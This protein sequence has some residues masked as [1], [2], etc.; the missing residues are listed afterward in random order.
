MKLSVI[1]KSEEILNLIKYLEDK[2]LVSYDCETTGL[3][4]ESKVIG[5]SV[6]ASEEEAFYVILWK[7]DVEE[8]KLISTGIE[9]EAK[10][11]ITNLTFKSLIM[12][13]AIFDC[14]MAMSNFKIDLMPSLHTDTMI[15]AHLLNENRRV[16][17][18][19]LG[20]QYFGGDSVK[21]MIEMRKSIQAN[22][23]SLTRDNY[24]LYK[25]DADLIGYYG[26]K[27]TLLTYKLFLE[28]VPELYEQGLDKFFYEEE[29]MP[30][31]KGPTYELNTTGLKVDVEGLTSLKKQLEAECLEAKDFIHEEIKEHVKEKYPGTNKRNQFN[32]GSANH[33]SWLLFGKLGFE[34]GRLTD[35]G[36]DVCHALNL[37]IPYAISAK[38]TFIESVTRSKGEVYQPEAIINGKKV[39][40]KKVKDP[41]TYI[42]VDKA[43]LQ[44]LA[45]KRKWIEKLLEY[46]RKLKILNTYVTGLEER[47]HYGTISPSFLQHGTTSGRYS[48]RAPNFQNL[49]RDDKRVKGIIT[50]RPGKVFVGA[51][52]SQLEPRVFAYFSNDKRLQNAFES[53]EDFYSVIGQGVYGKYDCTPTKEG[54]NAFGVKYKKLRDMTKAFALAAVYGA[55]PA[56]LASITG[57]SMD[58]IRN[59]LENYFEE[60]PDVAKFMKASHKIAKETG[61]V[62][63]LFGRPRRMPEA[64]L[65]DKIYG[66]VEHDELP[67]EARNVL[68]LAV[69]HTVQ[70][71]G[72]S[73]VN[74]S[75]IKLYQNLRDSGIIAKFVLQVH[76]SLILE[77]DEKDA[78]DVSILL[79]D[80][81]EN[82][83]ELPG[84]KLEAVPK[85]GKTLAEV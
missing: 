38:R 29:S 64:K 24:E 43:T 44:A 80:A 83:V 49:P 22:G 74:R 61:M 4:K 7:W 5:F 10:A 27:D 77:C 1:D 18:K 9:E 81:M 69:N 78:S 84:V 65:F 19:D 3:S 66:D 20:Q 23:G 63:S 31:L 36:K 16:G 51:D 59:D 28:L 35:G 46:K 40:A 2:D 85:T 76:D 67:Y 52:Y 39:R 68:N 37:K 70:S 12:H 8:K 55:T 79:Q 6:C 72:A 73:I 60:F 47:I 30:L 34:F 13:N 26:A 17:L 58:D 41:W 11:L 57:K 33:L 42:Q 71:T 45:G 21:E 25:A 48:S 50:A 75:A 14:Q 15:L 82:T 53:S 54:E 56:R 62:K 32:I